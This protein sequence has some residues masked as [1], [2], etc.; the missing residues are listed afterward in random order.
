M[1]DLIKGIADVLNFNTT[2]VQVG[3]SDLTNEHAN[4][5]MRGGE[6][7][8]ITFIVGHLASTRCG[9][10]KALGATDQNPFAEKWGAGNEVGDASD[11]PDISELA[12][13][14]DEL[15]VMLADALA[16]ITDEQ[17]LAA[18]PN[19]LPVSDPSRRGALGFFSWHESYHTGQIGLIRTELGY[20]ALRF[21]L[22]E[23]MEAKAAGA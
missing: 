14:W 15:G 1:S 13:D 19:Q 23:H 18:W 8:S 9:M 2:L 11:Y 4:H 17:A 7:S 10:L 21:R 6:G 20:K 3:I 22:V 5:R 12:S 16:G